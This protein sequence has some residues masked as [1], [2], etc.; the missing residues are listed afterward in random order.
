MVAMV[1]TSVHYVSTDIEH[2]VLYMQ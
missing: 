1:T 2:N